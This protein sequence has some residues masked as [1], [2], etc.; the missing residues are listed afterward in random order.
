MAIKYFFNSCRTIETQKRSRTTELA[1][2]KVIDRYCIVNNASSTIEENISRS[3]IFE[4]C[5]QQKGSL[6]AIFMTWRPNRGLVYGKGLKMETVKR[7]HPKTSLHGSKTEIII[8][9][10]TITAVKT[11]NLKQ[12]NTR[13]SSTLIH[14]HSAVYNGNWSDAIVQRGYITALQNGRNHG[15]NDLNA[16]SDRTFPGISQPAT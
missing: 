2:R 15:D 14:L 6:L 9:I 5:L 11:S 7:W 13:A 3:R 1:C 16:S 8:I 4:P 12:H 10:I